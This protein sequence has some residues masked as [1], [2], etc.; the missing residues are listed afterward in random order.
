M[1]LLYY[2]YNEKHINPQR[3]AVW[4]SALPKNKANLIQRLRIPQKRHLSLL[5]LQLLN[6]GAKQLQLPEFSLA[7]VQFPASDKPFCP[8]CDFSISH[9]GDLVICAIAQDH[10][11]G[12]DAEQIRPVNSAIFKRHLTTEERQRSED[13]AP[14]F[15][16][17]WTQ[18]EAI[19]KAADSGGIKSI[20]EIELS[21]TGGLLA[22]QHWY[23]QRVELMPEYMIYVA[24]DHKDAPCNTRQLTISDLTELESTTVL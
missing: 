14:Q 15:F 20:P 21:A 1:L 3:E 24:S 18:K 2:I 10:K 8:Q 11:V 5:G 17:Y 16:A 19:V 9:S 7:Q 12:I 23:T 6:Y 4:L 22:D 13:N